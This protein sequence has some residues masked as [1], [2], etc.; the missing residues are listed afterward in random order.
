MSLAAWL[1]VFGLTSCGMIT[2]AGAAQ[3]AP[4]A[5]KTDPI[6]EPEGLGAALKGADVRV[7]D[8]RDAADYE[9]SR[10]RGAVRFDLASWDPIT[11]SGSVPTAA[12][13]ARAV[14]ELGIGN[15]TKVVI[16]DAGGMTRAAAAWFILQHA[17]VDQPLVV[18]G[19]FKAVEA[20]AGETLTT[21]PAAKSPPAPR[22][23][24]PRAG[25]GL[26]GWA[27]KT[28]VND[29]IDR[30]GAHIWDAR[31]ADEY[32][33]KDA[34]SNKRVGHLPGAVNLGHAS[35]IGADG[36]LVSPEALRTMLRDKGFR[37]G[38]R[39]VAHCQGG[40]RSS[41]AALAAVR[42]GFGPVENYFMSFGEWSADETCRVVK[43]E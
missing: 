30:P 10:V 36:R 3:P 11:R 9:K 2:L 41:L 23:F 32:T 35:L 6:V 25:K 14:G 16:Y 28:A 38:D 18:N 7:L 5:A 12:A 29:A 4:G 31:T 1:V 21:E 40:G 27:N 20:A 43:P 33:G 26:V 24:E 42:A 13:L 37:P 34:R 39:I 22:A 8:L 15:T 17:G 19:G